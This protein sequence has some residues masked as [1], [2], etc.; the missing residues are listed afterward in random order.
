VPEGDSSPSLKVSQWTPSI[1]RIAAPVIGVPAEIAAGDDELREWISRPAFAA[2]PLVNELLELEAEFGI[3]AAADALEEALRERAISTT[4]WGELSAQELVARVFVEMHAETGAS[5]DRRVHDAVTGARLRT[6]NLHRRVS[7]EFTGARDALMPHAEL[8][9]FVDRLRETFAAEE[10]GDDVAAEFLDGA[11]YVGRGGRLRAPV[12]VKDGHRVP[13]VHR[14]AVT[15]VMRYDAPSGTMRI[16]A[17]NRRLARLYADALGETFFAGKSHFVESDGLT[18]EPLK[19]GV[20]ALDPSDGFVIERVVLK[21]FVGWSGTFSCSG[22]ARDLLRLVEAYPEVELTEARLHLRLSDRTRLTVIVRPD[23]GVVVD[24]K[25]HQELVES[26]LRFIGVRGTGVSVGL[27]LWSAFPWEQRHVSWSEVFGTEVDALAA[28]GVFEQ[29]RLAT[30]DNAGG[31]ETLLVDDVR[32]QDGDFYGHGR[33]PEDGARVLTG[34]DVEG[35]RLL[36]RMLAEHVSRGL[37]CTANVVDLDGG[38]VW[39][40]GRCTLVEGHGVELVLAIGAPSK[41]V[42]ELVRP[43][44]G[45]AP[46]IALVPLGRHVA[47]DPSVSIDSFI[48]WRTCRARIAETLGVAG[49]LPL[50]ER[51]PNNLAVRKAAGHVGVLG[52][53]IEFAPDSPGFKYVLKLAESFPEPV[54]TSALDDAVG[55]FGT[56]MEA[57][58]QAKLQLKKALAAQ[59]INLDDDVLSPKMRGWVGLKLAP[60]VV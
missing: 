55:A 25:E 38:R 32:A 6:A 15:D 19:R 40:L 11:L 60:I 16:T 51:Y 56:D 54:A 37:R 18:L 8:G 45:E 53:L 43:S 33:E 5:A 47:D 27:D 50:H 46:F 36:P 35:L 28:A 59:G 41:R 29:V 52:K 42:R 24:K 3:E 44:I 57:G 23:K 20:Q 34:S 26:Y 12:V 9:R 22:D 30:V 17:R 1:W 58:R 48:E 10:Y 14:P 2:D 21:K 13:L 31:P 49:L 4:G 7:Y 39:R